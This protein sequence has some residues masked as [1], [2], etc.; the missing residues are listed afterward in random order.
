LAISLF[1][2]C[3]TETAENDSNTTANDATIPN[4]N[5]ENHTDT[6][7]EK[8]FPESDDQEDE[9]HKILPENNITADDTSNE[10]RRNQTEAEQS[11]E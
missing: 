11:S 7:M 8:S 6:T 4:T 5:D 1:T 9:E 2:A 3:H 10:E